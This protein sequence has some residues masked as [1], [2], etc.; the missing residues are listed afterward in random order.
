[1]KSD[2]ILH[3]SWS[4]RWSRGLC[5]VRCVH[6]E[7]YRCNLNCSISQCSVAPY[8]W[9]LCTANELLGPSQVCFSRRHCETERLWIVA[10]AFQSTADSL[11]ACSEG[12]CPPVVQRRHSVR[13]MTPRFLTHCTFLSLLLHPSISPLHFVS[14]PSVHQGR[15]PGYFS[16]L[17]PFSPAVW[18][19]MLLAY[20]AVSCVLFLAARS[21]HFLT[22]SVGVCHV[23]HELPV[24][25]PH[26]LP[27]TTSRRQTD[28][29]RM[30]DW[31]WLEWSEGGALLYRG[32]TSRP[33]NLYSP[34]CFST[35]LSPYEWYNPHPCLR[36]RR[37]V[38]ENQYTLGNS[39]WF[40]IGGFMQQG[41]EIM[42]R[43]LS[44]RCVS[45]VWWVTQSIHVIAVV[46][47]SQ[48]M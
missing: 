26:V 19:F 31:C 42:P 25:Y 27:N 13:D 36:E 44:T 12:H 45:G 14:L 15:K 41:S 30:T 22:Q 48:N 7:M 9:Q 17:D 23:E 4:H 43:A 10:L 24:R 33:F 2:W 35:R 40:P 34:L 47:Y 39:L 11:S 37:D 6:G 8:Q 29:D 18:L 46:Y 5:S 20:L 21:I 38:L 32:L 16:F 3:N 28:S 1:M